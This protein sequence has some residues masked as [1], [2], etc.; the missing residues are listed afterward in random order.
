MLQPFLLFELRHLQG[1]PG[2]GKKYLVTQSYSRGED[3]LGEAKTPL[4]VSDYDD[5]GLAKIHFNAVRDDKYAA[6]VDLTNQAHFEKIKAL[7]SEGSKYRLFWNTVHK[8]KELVERVNAR[9]QDHM[10]RY[11]AKNTTWRISRDYGFTPDIQVIFGE[12]FAILKYG[13]ETKR[14]KFEEIEKS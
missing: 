4:L 7:L 10:R 5:I 1:L 13:R 3:H 9:Y 12:V 8:K 14:V 6:I 2:L 11:L